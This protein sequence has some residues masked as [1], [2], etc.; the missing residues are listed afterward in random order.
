MKKII[1]NLLL[2]IGNDSKLIVVNDGSK[3]KTFEIMQKI[4]EDKPALIPLT[5][6]NS[7]HG[8]T[9]LYA[10]RYAINKGADYI[11]QTDSQRE[12]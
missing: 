12:C 4:V 1:L 9:L 3:D 5:K 10:Y 11:F 7:G 2:M 8:P 6:Q